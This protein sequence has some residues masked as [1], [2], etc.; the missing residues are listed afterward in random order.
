MWLSKCAVKLYLSCFIDFNVWNVYLF[1][2]RAK[3]AASIWRRIIFSFRRPTGAGSDFFPACK[4]SKSFKR[5]GK[6]QIILTALG[7]AFT[8][9][10][11]LSVSN[12]T[13]SFHLNLTKWSSCKH[14]ESSFLPNLSTNTIS[15]VF[16]IALSMSSFVS[17][18]SRR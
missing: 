14:V 1:Q 17:R 4:I 16:V 7:H 6:H 11:C 3:N 12:H 2:D 9:E 13:V 5:P 8:A 10:D 15:V 18:E